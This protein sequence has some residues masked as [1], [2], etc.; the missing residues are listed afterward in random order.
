MH[1]IFEINQ[2]VTYMIQ[3]EYV[4]T[5]SRGNREMRTKI[6]AEADLYD[7]ELT[8]AEKI[9]AILSDYPA[10]SDVISEGQMEELTLALAR[11]SS[12]II[13]AL[14]PVAQVKS[15]GTTERRTRRTKEQI[16]QDKREKNDLPTGVNPESIDS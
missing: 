16:E 2:V 6:Q 11:N 13:D 4:V 5:D 9:Q 15:S 12:A 3:I 10:L 8:A 7:K 14:K 1:T